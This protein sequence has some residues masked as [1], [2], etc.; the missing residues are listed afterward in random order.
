MSC[1]G[2][3]S[4]PG[5]H[6]RCASSL[7]LAISAGSTLIMLTPDAVVPER[8]LGQHFVGVY[9]GQITVV[10][11]EFPV[12]PD[13]ADV[14]ASG[15][16]DQMRLR[17]V[18]RRKLGPGKPHRRDVGAFPGLQRADRLVQAERARGPDRRQLERLPCW[19]RSR[20]FA[21]AFVTE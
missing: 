9:G 11:H 1:S 5:S 4:L 17:I 18:A 10:H 6:Q 3:N 7:N 19:L 8:G 2:L 20:A 21:H 13:V 16:V 14:L 15:G 12:D